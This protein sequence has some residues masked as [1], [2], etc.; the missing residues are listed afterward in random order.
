M[1][2]AI[3]TPM[4]IES[5]TFAEF[6]SRLTNVLDSFKGTK[7][8][9]FFVVDNVSKDNTLDLC[10]ELSQTDTRYS[11]IFATENKNVV[12]AYIRGYREA[13]KYD[14]DYII[15]MDAGLSHTPET[16]PMFVEKLQQ[17]FD[18]VFGSRF[19]KG[20]DIKDSNWRRK[21]L[22]KGGTLLANILLGTKMKDMTSGFM[23]FKAQT[24]KRFAE[25]Q[26]LSKAHFYQTEVR[27]LLRKHTYTEI[28]IIYCAPSPRV[29]FKAI[30][31][32]FSVLFHYFFGR[33]T[34]KNTAL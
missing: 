21:L 16:I 6:T 19:I 12:D 20:G 5:E 2:F 10:H 27:Y 33:I 31:N 26:L 25:Y 24:A 23:G 22:S 29:S 30:A 7:V 9:V 3:V 14:F 28:P 32:S 1:S 34:G 18:C 11:T 13:L 4:A 15:E 17:G 8:Q